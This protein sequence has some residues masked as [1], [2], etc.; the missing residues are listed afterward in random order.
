MAALADGIDF[1]ANGLLRSTGCVSRRGVKATLGVFYAVTAFVVLYVMPAASDDI[2]YWSYCMF[3]G[4]SV[5]LLALGSVIAKVRLTQSVA[6][7][8][9]Q[10]F[11]LFA[12]SIACR[13]ACNVL[14]E[15]YLPADESGDL[16][17]PL[18]EAGC[19]CCVCYILYA[20][21]KQYTDTYDV[22]QDV[23][24]LGPLVG[25]C[26]IA[27]TCVRAELN[28][29]TFEDTL[30]AF[31]L[32]VETFRMLPQLFLFAKVGGLVDSTQAHF[33]ANNFLAAV[34]RTVFWLSA[35]PGCPELSHHTEDSWTVKVG[36]KYI[37][38]MHAVHLL[39]LFDFMYHYIAA[40]KNG[41]A[42]TLPADA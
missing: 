31:A 27:A 23:F 17:Y 16:A 21:H 29:D 12:L 7:L 39:I 1:M 15:G 10:T 33:V 36:G 19:L 35:V 25:S 20:I 6:G 22:D 14:N 9:S 24:P 26:L 13:C 5:Q 3:M 28:Q 11:A 42:V 4:S 2:A 30:W 40:W 38:G 18:V 8:S 32:N 41:T 34:L 37:L